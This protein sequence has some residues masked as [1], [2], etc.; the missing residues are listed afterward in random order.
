MFYF[1]S[2]F[3][4]NMLPKG[5]A[6]LH[7][8]SIQRIDAG[9][10]RKL[11]DGIRGKG[12]IPSWEKYPEFDREDLNFSMGH[13]LSCKYINEV[14]GEELFHFERTNVKLEEGDALVVVQYS[15]PRLKEGEVLSEL[16]PDSCYELYLVHLLYS[17]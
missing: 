2:S 5:E 8:L 4:I 10:L 14:L 13:E 9:Y 17:F 12:E 15:G 3:S 11:V 7:S 16:P 1:N 6:W